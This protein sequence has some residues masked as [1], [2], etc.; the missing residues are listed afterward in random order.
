[1]RRNRGE[2]DFSKKTISTGR[3]IIVII[4]SIFAILFI[5][6]GIYLY[7]VA[8]DPEFLETTGNFLVDLIIE[9]IGITV[10]LDV[11]MTISIICFVIGGILVLI[12]IIL[13][14]TGIKKKKY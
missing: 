8:L 1:M 11:A 12:A 3:I 13:L 6:S 14:L 7:N 9:L 4:T 2:Y 5:L 10:I